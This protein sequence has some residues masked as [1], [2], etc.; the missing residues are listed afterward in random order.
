MGYKYDLVITSQED[1]IVALRD[2][3][4]ELGHSP[5]IEEYK[6]LDTPISARTIIRKCDSWNR[7]KELAGLAVTH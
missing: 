4:E 2:A 3:A 6:S 7:A 1:C 5:T